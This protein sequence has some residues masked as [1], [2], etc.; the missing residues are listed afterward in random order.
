MSSTS[1]PVWPSPSISSTVPIRPPHRSTS[2]SLTGASRRS[3]P[4]RCSLTLHGCILSP[5]RTTTIW[6]SKGSASPGPR[7]TRPRPLYPAST[8]CSRVSDPRA[9]APTWPGQN[10]PRL[11]IQDQLPRREV[12]YRDLS[13]AL[14]QH[15]SPTLSA[16]LPVTVLAVPSMFV[17]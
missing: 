3:R 1:D 17:S 7:P 8:M 16:I 5:T 15:W 4:S 13:L 6:Y 14:E 2:S 10:R 11:M 12:W 9:L